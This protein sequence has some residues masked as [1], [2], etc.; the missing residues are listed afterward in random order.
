MRE[1]LTDGAERLRRGAAALD[2][3]EAMVMALETDQ[4]QKILEIKTLMET[5]I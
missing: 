2:V 5:E 3:V 4:N 1:R